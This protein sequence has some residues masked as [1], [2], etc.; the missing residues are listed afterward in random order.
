MLE[1][2]DVWQPLGEFYLDPSQHPHIGRVRQFDLSREEP[3]R[4]ISFGPVRWVPLLV[5]PGQGL[6]YDSP[7]G[8]EE[9]RR[10]PFPTG[11]YI[12][13]KYPIW[14]GD[15]FD[16]N[17]FL[18]WYTYGIHTG[19]DLNLPGVSAADQGKPIYAVA[20]GLMTY[21]GKAGSWG[22]I[23]VIEHPEAVVSRPDGEVA[24]QPAFS[25]YGHVDDQIL[26]RA[27]EMVTRGQHIGYIGLA[28]GAKSGWH[29][30]FDVSYSDI[31]KSRP[32]FWPDITGM[33][34]RPSDDYSRIRASIQREV[35]R[36]FV[37]PLKFIQE[38]HSNSGN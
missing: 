38:N 2:L 36:H 6:R 20:D 27:G 1:L 24:R 34:T 4:E 19:A 33:R 11:R 29:L 31:F 7:V 16:A 22:N 37:A 21:A 17:P 26:A 10:A 23:I 3:P 5:P 18:T 35:L 9:E 14:T 32:A 15:W 28:W 8:T 30:H 13:G 12:F 25:R